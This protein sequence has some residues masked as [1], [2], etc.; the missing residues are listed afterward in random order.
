MWD[1]LLELYLGLSLENLDMSDAFGDSGKRFKLYYMMGM[2]LLFDG[3]KAEA[4]EFFQKLHSLL[5][6]SF[7]DVQI[8][9]RQTE[10]EKALFHERDVLH[11]DED[12]KLIRNESRVRELEEHLSRVKDQLKNI[13]IDPDSSFWCEYKSKWGCKFF[14]EWVQFLKTQVTLLGRTR[15]NL[16]SEHLDP[17]MESSDK[18]WEIIEKPLE[19]K[20]RLPIVSIEGLRIEIERKE[21][22]EKYY[23]Q[24]LKCIQGLI[25][26]LREE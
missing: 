23:E 25:D 17:L 13:Q 15:S 10:I 1:N 19:I 26:F 9:N 3:N 4:A 14:Y 24:M 22:A 2:S 21:E 18:I 7:D 11:Y 12:W 20:G 8:V 16:V 6:K 5:K